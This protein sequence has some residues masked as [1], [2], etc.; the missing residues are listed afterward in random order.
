MGEN[1]FLHWHSFISLFQEYRVAYN[2]RENRQSGKRR[3]K[4]CAPELNTGMYAAMLLN[5]DVMGMFTGHDHGNDYIALYNGIA[6]A[7][8]RFSGGKTTYTKTSNGAR[9]IEIREGVRGFSSYIRL[10][11]G[12]I[13]DVYDYKQN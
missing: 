1:L 12:K 6:L 8:G 3:E 2:I 5:G 7:Y 13:V 11:N 4:E 9:V 10:S